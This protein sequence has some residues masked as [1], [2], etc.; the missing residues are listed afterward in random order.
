MGQNFNKIKTIK[1]NFSKER[2]MKE[3]KMITNHFIFDFKND[4]VIWIPIFAF[5]VFSLV[6]WY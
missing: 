1:E 4:L 2:K 3:R 5:I 6:W